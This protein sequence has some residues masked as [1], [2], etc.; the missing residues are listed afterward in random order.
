LFLG[1]SMLVGR[2]ITLERFPAK[3]LPLCVA[4]MRSNKELEPRSDAI[5]TKKVLSGLTLASGLALGLLWLCPN[6]AHAE[7]L[8]NDVAVFAALDKVTARI[9]PLEIKL[10]QTVIFGAFK[11]T[12]RV[13][14]TR[15]ATEAPVTTAFV[16]IDETQLDG[17][18]KRIFTGWMFAQSPGLHGVEHPVFDVWLTNCKTPHDEK[19]LREERA[20]APTPAPR[21]ERRPREERAPREERQ[22]REKPSRPRQSPPPAQPSP[23]PWAAQPR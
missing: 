21:E 12:P 13:C 11:V 4:K 2:T 23:S 10:G 16:E 22:P 8:V 18:A 15:P 6:P 20:A 9:S 5:G 19:P 1:K 7:K 3:W 14:N 17:K